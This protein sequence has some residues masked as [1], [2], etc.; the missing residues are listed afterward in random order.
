MMKI[1]NKPYN[2]NYFDKAVDLLKE[3]WDF[4]LHFKNLKDLD[5]PYNY[6]LQEVLINCSYCR[7]LVDEKDQ[8]LGFIFAEMHE[9]S[10]KWKLFKLNAK[11]LI[12]TLLGDFGKRSDAFSFFWQYSRDCKALYKGSRFDNEVYLLAVSQK[13]K[14][15]GLGKKLINN[16]L[17]ECR[18][19]KISKIG[20]QTASDCNYNFYD[21]M[22]FE[23][24]SS[25]YTD[26]YEPGKEDENFFIYT[27]KA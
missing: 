21:Y 12:S 25:M 7:I 16:Y 26:M 20:L 8:V 13:A 4:T 19:N 3:T 22:G 14:G 23:R 27:M 10:N 1:E 6:Y 5:V 9:K 18:N 15:K 17:K 11:I 24:E 2:S